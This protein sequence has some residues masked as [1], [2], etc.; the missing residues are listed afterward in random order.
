V[1]PCE[2]LKLLDDPLTDNDLQ[3]SF[4]DID[5]AQEEVLIQES[6]DNEDLCKARFFTT[7]VLSYKAF[8]Y[9]VVGVKYKIKMFRVGM[10]IKIFR[11]QEYLMSRLRNSTLFGI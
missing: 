10:L 5:Y 9:Q 11:N 1:L 3:S 7:L 6:G 4:S 2:I 8:N